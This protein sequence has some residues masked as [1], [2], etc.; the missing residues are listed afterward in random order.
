MNNNQ[1]LM[2]IFC[3]QYCGKSKDVATCNSCAAAEKALEIANQILILERVN[4]SSVLSIK[5]VMRELDIVK[6]KLGIV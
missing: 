3:D 5:T 2:E 6:N 4:E 1:T